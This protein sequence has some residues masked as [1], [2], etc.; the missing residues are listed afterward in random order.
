MTTTKLKHSRKS[1]DIEIREDQC[2]VLAETNEQLSA[3]NGNLRSV[4]MVSGDV[5]LPIQLVLSNPEYEIVISAY[6]VSRL[7]ER[8]KV[9]HHYCPGGE[10]SS[11]ASS[12][13]LCPVLGSKRDDS[14]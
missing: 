3:T 11:V 2:A 10:I 7:V 12:S 13:Q 1:R 5:I 8:T 9:K 6:L 4:V 14:S